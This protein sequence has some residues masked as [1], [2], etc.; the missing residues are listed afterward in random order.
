MTL[1]APERRARHRSPDGYALRDRLSHRSV[2]P[3]A[4]PIG[5]LIGRPTDRTTGRATP[6]LP[7]C[8]WAVAATLVVWTAASTALAVWTTLHGGFGR[9]LT[10]LA[11][12]L[13][14]IVIAATML[15]LCRL[16]GK[17]V[18][19]EF[20]DTDELTGLA[21][22]H[23]FLGQAARLLGEHS[24]GRPA[25][26]QGQG[27]GRG[28]GEPER[29][30][31]VAGALMLI[32][33]DRFSEINSSL[34]HEQGDRLL[35]KVGQRVRASG[36]S[37]DIVARI[38]GDEFAVLLR[39]AGTERVQ[40]EAVSVRDALR[41]PVMLAGMPVPVEAS[42]GIA[43]AP[44][45]GRDVFEL[46]RNATSALGEAK[47]SLAGHRVYDTSCGRISPA[48]LRLRA[49]LRTC[50]QSGQIEPHYQPKANLRTGRIT[51]MEALVR[52]RHPVEG[53]R[54]PD[55]FLPDMQA[56]G[57]MPKLTGQ[58]LTTALADCA[59]WHAAGAKLSVSVNVP[60][61]VIVDPDFVHGVH[62]ALG[63][64]GVPPSALCVEI[65]ED[66]L[67]T[68][69]ESAQHTLARLRALGVRVSLDDY[70]SGYCSLAYLRDLPA[71]E[72]KLDRAFL[73]DIERN[74]A[75]GE[76]V[77]STV[78]LA[79][80]LHLRMVAEG[81][82]TDRSWALLAGWGCD[83]AQ[84]YFVSPPMVGE[85][86]LPWLRQWARRTRPSRPVPVPAPLSQPPLSQPPLSQP[87]SSL[88]SS[89]R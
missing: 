19:D 67:M 42:I 26:R 8:P 55:T 77:R 35:V 10:G 88:S 74:P 56:A 23:G 30:G 12:L 49:E 75:A 17:R 81:V 7:V 66:S 11:C 34:G 59:R 36:R 76:I 18:G 48:R 73:R 45:H 9:W 72:I 37:G 50:L 46:L 5:R 44:D 15:L 80:T 63:G 24:D 1:F 21:N 41:E 68:Q 40:A 6:M 31:H 14:L 79:H 62:D 86:V 32:D 52:W 47:K 54:P 22:R 84:G 29:S 51:G 69:R 4:D 28:Q 43:I 20:A 3:V 33:I 57:L 53:I 78:A 89:S 38:G 13:I 70:G 39:S 60:A 27:R 71:D 2:R 82:E 61:P 65:T 83:E 58:V 87:P 25:R 64:A 85:Q 16:R